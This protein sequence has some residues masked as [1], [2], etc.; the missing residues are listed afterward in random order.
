M[1]AEYITHLCLRLCNLL[2][3]DLS[4]RC[5][6]LDDSLFSTDVFRDSFGNSFLL[7]SILKFYLGQIRFLT[8][9]KNKGC[10]FSRWPYSAI[11]RI[12]ARVD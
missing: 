9:C 5:L 10:F 6:H 7:L 2:G 8:R 1:V 4:L 3:L 11:Q 12:D